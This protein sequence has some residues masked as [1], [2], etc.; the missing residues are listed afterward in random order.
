MQNRHPSGRGGLRCP[1]A[2]AYGGCLLGG[3]GFY[4]QGRT[5]GGGRSDCVWLSS[6][7]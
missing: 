4:G 2:L 1:T 3:C 6:R 7:N 5:V